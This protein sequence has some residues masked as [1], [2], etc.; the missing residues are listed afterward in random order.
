MDTPGFVKP[1]LA[2]KREA[3]FIQNITIQGLTYLDKYNKI[4]EVEVHVCI[5]DQIA[6]RNESKVPISV[7]IDKDRGV[8]TLFTDEEVYNLFIYGDL[9]HCPMKSWTVE[10]KAGPLAVGSDDYNRF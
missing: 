7:Q 1:I 5:D 10:S 3:N 8:K 6:L 2:I 9:V 4:F